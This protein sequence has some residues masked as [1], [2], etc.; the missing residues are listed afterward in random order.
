M[1]AAVLRC[2]TRVGNTLPRQ[3][4]PLAPPFVPQLSL[5][6]FSPLLTHEGDRSLTLLGVMRTAAQEGRVVCG[7]NASQKALTGISDTAKVCLLSSSCTD[8]D[9]VA[10]VTTICSNRGIPLYSGVDS[11]TLGAWAGLNK[12]DSTGTIIS[13]LSCSCVVVKAPA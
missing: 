1:S 10:L 12:R 13:S 9:Y 2:L 5:R 8:L 11:T 7:L 6:T 3:S 4:C